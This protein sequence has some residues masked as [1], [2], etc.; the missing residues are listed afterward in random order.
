MAAVES[1]VNVVNV[2]NKRVIGYLSEDIWTNLADLNSEI[3][4]RVREINE[5]IRRAD[6]TTRWE[7]FQAEEASQLAPLPGDRFEEV[8][9]KE[10]KV[11]RN[12]H[13]SC[14]FQHYSVPVKA[15]GLHRGHKP[16]QRGFGCFS[17]DR[18]F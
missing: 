10:L 18:G 3:A 16:P 17:F 13:L 5:E 6:D 1:A 14:D 12:Y 9:W 15:Q 7:V 8:D 11:G 4:V 2:V